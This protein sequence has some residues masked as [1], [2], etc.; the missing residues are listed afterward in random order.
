MPSSYEER[1]KYM[2]SS[3][4][5]VLTLISMPPPA[6][7]THNADTSGQPELPVVSSRHIHHQQKDA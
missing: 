5:S 1:G 7:G 4:F 6:A 3:Q 2:I